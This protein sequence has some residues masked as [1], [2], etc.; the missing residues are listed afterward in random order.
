MLLPLYTLV[1][2]R[3]AVA[4]RLSPAFADNQ[5]C[6]AIVDPD[7]EKTVVETIEARGCEVETHKVMNTPAP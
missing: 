6:G 2:K 3:W 1:A 5:A 4:R 7:V